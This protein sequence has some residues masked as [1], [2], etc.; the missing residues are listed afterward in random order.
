MTRVDFYVSP[1][2]A[3]NARQQVACRLAA[4]AFGAGARVHIH[5]HDRAAAEELDRMLWVFRDGAFVP[6]AIVGDAL[7]D[8]PPGPSPVVL[9]DGAAPADDCTLL[10]N[11]TDEVPE[12]FSRI[13][14]V[15]EIVDARPEQRDSGRARFRFYR[16]RGYAVHTHKLQAAQ[17]VRR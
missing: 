7:L 9:G 5:V 13:D 3:A 14:R 2:S 10:I 16:D 4:K 1:E 8:S 17:A 15:A 11:L 6:H 12:F